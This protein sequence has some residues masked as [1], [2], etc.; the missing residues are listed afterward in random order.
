[1]V[2]NTVAIIHTQVG[3]YHIARANA[4]AQVF[5]GSVQLIQLAS[6]EAQRSWTVEVDTDIAIA[7][8]ADGVLE[9]INARFLAKQLTEYLTQLSPQAIVVAGYSHPAMRAAI[10][11]ARQQQIAVVLLSDSQQLDHPRNPLRE[12]F[13]G[14]W[15]RRNCD[16]AFVAG[17][18]AA[19]YLNTLGFPRNRIW[20]GYDVVDHHYFAQNSDLVKQSEHLVRQRLGLP[21]K[22]FLYVGRFSTEKNLLRLLNAYRLYSQHRGQECWSLVMVGSG[23]QEIESTVKQFQLELNHLYWVGFQQIKE[24]PAYYSLAS[25]LVLPSVSEPW[26]LVVNEAMACG[27]PI[28]ISDRCGCVPDLV[29]PGVNGYIFNPQ[30]IK[31]VANAMILMSSSSISQ[32]QA[33][34][35]ASK[36]IVANY[37]PERWA[38]ALLN[39]LQYFSKLKRNNMLFV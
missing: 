32:Q 37:T 13:K 5:A 29:F 11:W 2:Q 27:L 4:L 23:A 20:R 26:G 38:L 1:M 14:A 8:I 6:R 30:N 25:A 21:E 3:P 17:A 28:L 24:L 12:F 22:Y 39:C 36:Q 16:A 7:T 33:M 34:Q 10:R 19:S 15:I 31:E 18:S 9:E 35:Q